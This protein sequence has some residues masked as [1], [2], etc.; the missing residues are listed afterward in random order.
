MVHL[1][2][3]VAG[4]LWWIIM[5][6]D[7]LLI[8]FYLLRLFFSCFHFKLT[9]R[10]F[11]WPY[12]KVVQTPIRN[13][14]SPCQRNKLQHLTTWVN[15]V[16]PY[17]CFEPNKDQKSMYTLTMSPMHL[18]ICSRLDLKKNNLLYNFEKLL[19]IFVLLRM[20]RRIKSKIWGCMVRISQH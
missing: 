17:S 1:L 19:T 5:P 9:I 10:S 18:S 13:K 3:F 7:D 2:S 4:S 12:K 20:S 6:C 14:T 8:D 16:I 15:C 11:L